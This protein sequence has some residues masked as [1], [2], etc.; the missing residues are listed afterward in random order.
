MSAVQTPTPRAPRAAL[1]ALGERTRSSRW[2]RRAAT[3]L[4]VLGGLLYANWV[5]QV[6]L[7]VE[8]GLRNSFISELSAHGQP[9]ADLFRC[10][11]I[12]GGV[13]M[14]AGGLL[15]W[16]LRRD[17]TAVWV[18]VVL[19]G[20][21][22]IVEAALPLEES[23][24]FGGG[25]DPRPGTSAWWA[26]ISEPHGVASLVDSLCFLVLLWLC[27]RRLRAAGL[28]LGVRR[29]LLVAGVVAAALGFAQAGQ[30]A[31]FLIVGHAIDLGLVQ[32]LQ[33]LL[34]ALWLAAAPALLLRSRRRGE[35]R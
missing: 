26:R 9:F 34:V 35:S 17:H 1:T 25:P 14:V 18:T 33:V 6:L 27:S 2:S 19:L 29:A 21:A 10:L 7:P 23:M 5:L 20:A 28:R 13:L 8:A 31:L 3:A 11:D 4:L 15:A 16:W 30:T 32:R 24:T 12:T 22:V